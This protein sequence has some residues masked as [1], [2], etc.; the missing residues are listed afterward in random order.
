MKY[1]SLSQLDELAEIAAAEAPKGPGRTLIVHST[2]GWINNPLFLRT[3]YENA[4][5]LN[6]DRLICE[7]GTAVSHMAVWWSRMQKFRVRTTIV[8]IDPATPQI[9]DRPRRYQQMADEGPIAALFFNQ[10]AHWIDFAKVL[11]ERGIPVSFVYPVGESLDYRT[12][13]PGMTSMPPMTELRDIRRDMRKGRPRKL[14]TEAEKA[15]RKEHAQEKAKLK[16]QI[17]RELARRFFPSGL[18]RGRPRKTTIT[19][20]G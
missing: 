4:V 17:A 14:L 19:R 11:H 20:H 15:E 16:R 8:L 7:E 13:K 6:V 2:S 5:S 1:D 9:Q 18:P 12:W 10:A 3:M